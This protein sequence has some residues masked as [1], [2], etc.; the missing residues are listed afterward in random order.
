MLLSERA[1]PETGIPIGVAL[2]CTRGQRTEKGP[3]EQLKKFSNK[4][5]CQILLVF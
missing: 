1:G 3:R 4:G 5:S 2:G